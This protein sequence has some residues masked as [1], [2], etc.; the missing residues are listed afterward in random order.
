MGMMQKS[1]SFIG[2]SKSISVPLSSAGDLRS[3][4]TL[5]LAGAQGR[6]PSGTGG[7]NPLQHPGGP[8]QPG[9]GLPARGSRKV[10]RQLPRPRLVARSLQ[11]FGMRPRS[12]KRVVACCVEP[13]FFYKVTSIHIPT[14]PSNNTHAFYTWYIL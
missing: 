5:P 7:A 1:T 8:D 14:F 9:F 10:A 13:E 6:V 3:V 12:S 2:D 4:H 11:Q